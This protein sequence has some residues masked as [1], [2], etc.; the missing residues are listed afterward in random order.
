MANAA[1]AATVVTPGA[2]PAYQQP[3][4]PAVL[5]WEG[6]VAAVNPAPPAVTGSVP[7]QET[8]PRPGNPDYH[9]QVT[10]GQDQSEAL[11]TFGRLQQRHPNL[12]GGYMPNIKKV[13]LGE[14]GVWYRVRV[15]PMVKR[16]AAIR[17]C[18]KLK[19]Q[20]GDC[21]IRTR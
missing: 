9:V 1:H 6:R 18:K 10:A 15:G 13:D 21:L 20:G 12:L 19:A 5:P 3:P 8:A 7:P 4:S 14:K 16:R 11:T 2:S 17:F